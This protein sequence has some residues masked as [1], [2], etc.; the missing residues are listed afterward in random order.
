MTSLLP[1]LDGRHDH[2]DAV[3]V[4]GA[5]CSW[6]ELAARADALGAAVAGAPA[7]A[8][9]GTPTLETVIAVVA[10]LRHGVPV[11]PVPADAG[12]M[13]RE[14]ILRDSGAGHRQG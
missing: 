4:D 11:V 3:M 1:V 13:E 2:P 5:T 6:E 14:H 9:C 8:V 10:G 7:L 12:P